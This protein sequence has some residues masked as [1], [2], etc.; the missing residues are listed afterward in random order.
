MPTRSAPMETALLK[1]LE[2]LP[3]TSRR[4]IHLRQFDFSRYPV[5]C[6]YQ[7]VTRRGRRY[8]MKCDVLDDGSLDV[9]CASL[10][11]D[12]V[13]RRMPKAKHFLGQLR[14]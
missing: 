13:P 7:G 12:R 5:L 10:R 4:T 9:S 6:W 2:R 3:V 8:S 11:G 14:T 1:K